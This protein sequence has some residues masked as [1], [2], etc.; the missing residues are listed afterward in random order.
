MQNLIDKN[1]DDFKENTLINTFGGIQNKIL[2]L[3][4]FESKKYELIVLTNNY[5]LIFIDDKGNK[6]N[7]VV[8]DYE[9]TCFEYDYINNKILVGFVNG[10]ISFLEAERQSVSDG[11]F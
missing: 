11:D 2:Q 6:I 10:N 1:V 4:I 3:K 9:P 5:T 8:F 7:Q